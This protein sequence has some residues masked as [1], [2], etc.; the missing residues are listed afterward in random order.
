MEQ[1]VCERG[2]IKLSKESLNCFEKAKNQKINTEIKAKR[3]KKQKKMNY[4]FFSAVEK[5]KNECKREV[6]E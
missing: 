4:F 5:I 6:Q 3:G 2:T 1:L